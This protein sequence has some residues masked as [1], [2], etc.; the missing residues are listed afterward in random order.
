V[1]RGGGGG[2]IQHSPPNLW[3]TARPP[4]TRSSTCRRP[5]D[6]CHTAQAGEEGRRAVAAGLPG[7]LGLLMAN[8]QRSA[9]SPSLCLTY[10]RTRTHTHT[11]AHTHTHTHTR[12]RARALSLSLSARGA[13]TA[14]GQQATVCPLIQGYLAHKKLPPL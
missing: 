7:A 9:C 8:K 1:A 5:P 11:R 10:T 13:R 3:Q 4:S 2:D 14:H 6:T 12:T